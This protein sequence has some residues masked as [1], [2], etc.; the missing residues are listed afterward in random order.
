MSILKKIHGY[1]CR[2][3]YGVT[4]TKG[5]TY[6]LYAGVLVVVSFAIPLL[7]AMINNG[8]RLFLWLAVE[9]YGLYMWTQAETWAYRRRLKELTEKEAQNESNHSHSYV[10]RTS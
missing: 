8:E 1:F 7:I 2:G 6:L 5:E 4:Y 10:Q 9:T 3:K